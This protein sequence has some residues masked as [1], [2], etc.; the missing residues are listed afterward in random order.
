MWVPGL[1]KLT[2]AIIYQSVG[3]KKI[4]I[5]FKRSHVF[6]DSY[7]WD[8]CYLL[9]MMMM[10]GITRIFAF[11]GIDIHQYSLRDKTWFIWKVTCTLDLNKLSYNWYSKKLEVIIT[12]FV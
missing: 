3:A 8:N 12:L 6:R 2:D 4:N 1:L 7:F 5:L 10:P 11:F 9:W